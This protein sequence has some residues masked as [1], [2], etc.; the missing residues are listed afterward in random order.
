MLGDLNINSSAI[1]PLKLRQNP[2]WK[3]SGYSL[4][5]FDGASIDGGSNC[6]VGGT[7]NLC[8]SQVFKWYFNGGVGTN[9]KDEL[10]GAWETLIMA[11]LL[12][13]QYIQVLGDSKVIID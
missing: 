6:G 1:K 11:R 7:I 13:T 4:A 2:I 5:F 9:T 10:L 12:D 8:N 3:L